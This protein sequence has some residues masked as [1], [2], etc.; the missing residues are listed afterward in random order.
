MPGFHCHIRCALRRLG[1]AAARRVKLEIDAI[2]RTPIAAACAAFRPKPP[3][4]S[5]NVILNSGAKMSN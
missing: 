1:K 4:L 2:P 5:L 3:A